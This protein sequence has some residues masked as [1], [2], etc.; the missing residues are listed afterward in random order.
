MANRRIFWLV[1][2]LRASL[3]LFTA[4]LPLV[5]FLSRLSSNRDGASSELENDVLGLFIG[6]GPALFFT[7]LF[8]MSLFTQLRFAVN[9]YRT[10]EGGNTTP[11]ATVSAILVENHERATYT[12]I[13]H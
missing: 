5:G 3:F 13:S 8:H 2:S 6:G 7:L 11:E 10:A 12:A 9:F 4:R 1:R